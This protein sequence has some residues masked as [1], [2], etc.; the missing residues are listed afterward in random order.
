MFYLYVLKSTRY[1]RTYIGITDNVTHRI[2]EHNNGYVRSTKA[3]RPYTLIYTETLT[4]KTEA[5]QRE[6]K[7]K[8]HSQSKEILFRKLG[9]YKHASLNNPSVGGPVV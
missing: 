3:Y 9:L 7:L 5:R 2:N 4:T 8:S 1:R 6:I